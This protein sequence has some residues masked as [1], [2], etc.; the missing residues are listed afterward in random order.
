MALSPETWEL[1]KA[2]GDLIAFLDDDVL[3]DTNYYEEIE[4]IFIEYPDALGVHGYNKLTNKAYEENEKK[5]I[6]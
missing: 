1:Q 6:I 3:L 2:K 4:K 5:Y